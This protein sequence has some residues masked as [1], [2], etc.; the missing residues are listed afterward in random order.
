MKSRLSLVATL[1]A[2]SAP[3]LAAQTTDQARLVFS[4]GLGQTS[5]G[6]QLWRVGNQPLGTGDTV[7]VNRAFRNSLNISFSGT[8]FPNDNLG[9]NA[10]AQLLGLGTRDGCTIVSLA[11]P[12]SLTDTDEVC[13][14]LNSKKRGTSSGT[15]SV[16]VVYRVFSR[17]PI[18]PYVRANVG[19]L[20][21]QES[22]L[23]MVATIGG[24][25]NTLVDKPVY[26]DDS[27]DNLQPYFSFGGGIVTAIGRGYQLRFEVRDNW[28][29]VPVV[30]GPT[31][32][33]PAFVPTHASQGRHVI[34]FVLGFDVVLER[35]R[36][37]RY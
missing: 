35:K 12:D 37:R 23:K 6:G 29:R 16:G 2:L 7:T 27:P 11:Q 18:Y 17:S 21:S 32:G 19:M 14:S 36:G 24:S 10:E 1:V 28:V 3:A 4:V 5:G 8:Y 13:S 26:L 31:S 9:F 25:G 33:A 22:F 30:T 15:L 34:S 20:V